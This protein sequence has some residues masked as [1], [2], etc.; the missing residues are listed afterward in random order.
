MSDDD[1]WDD[2]SPTA[3]VVK[4]IPSST[5]QLKDL[6]AQW[7]NKKTGKNKPTQPAAAA[8]AQPTQPTAAAVTP[9]AT[10]KP[11][12][13]PKP[14]AIAAPSMIAAP[15]TINVPVDKVEKHNVSAID[16]ERYKDVY[17]LAGQ[18]DIPVAYMSDNGSVILLSNQ[19]VGT[20]MGHMCQPYMTVT[21]VSAE[22][23]Y[24]YKQ[25]N[26]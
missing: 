17:K 6:Y 5:E 16:L 22:T 13:Q 2:S 23:A 19:H 4:P 24:L 8:T 15:S 21:L 11:T 26:C 20:V 14:I 12:E 3:E 1:Q 7:K 18:I 10:D 9:R 25:R